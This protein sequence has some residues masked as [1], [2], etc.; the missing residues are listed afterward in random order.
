MGLAFTQAVPRVCATISITQ[1]K[2]RM[3]IKDFELCRLSVRAA[4]D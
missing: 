2:F 4:R 1:A 3:L